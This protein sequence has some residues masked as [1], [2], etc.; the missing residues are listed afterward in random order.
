VNWIYL[1]VDWVLWLT[2][3][4]IIMKICVSHISFTVLNIMEI[5]GTKM[6]INDLDTS[7]GRDVLNS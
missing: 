1:S 2:V 7:F 5:C 6:H 3:V 4:S